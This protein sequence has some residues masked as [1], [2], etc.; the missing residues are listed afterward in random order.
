MLD[1]ACGTGANLRELAPRLGGSQCWTLVD[2]DPA[3]LGALPGVLAAWTQANGFVLEAGATRMHIEGPGWNAEVR[4]VCIDLALELGAVPFAGTRL[5]T[6]SALL[7]LVSASWLDALFAHARMA[8]AA[9]LFALNVD[10][11]IAWNPPVAGDAEVDRLFASHQRRDKGFGPALGGTAVSFAVS[12]L[13]ALKYEVAQA[14]SDWRI[15]AGENASGTAML[16]AMVEGMGAAAIEQDPTAR[17]SVSE[18]MQRRID[19]LDHTSL[20]IGH[21]EILAT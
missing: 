18:W 3:L 9:M 2:H 17:A 11:R 7:D 13:R 16:T 14:A 6:A 1:L 10:G 19:V 8:G 5:V 21:Q 15:D 4:P 12:R 20:C